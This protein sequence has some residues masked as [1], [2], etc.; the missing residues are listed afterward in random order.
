METKDKK[1]VQDKSELAAK[2]FTSKFSYKN[3]PLGSYTGK[4]E[5]SNDKPE[6]DSDDL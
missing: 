6:Q 4:S 5:G 2:A 3:D 1:K